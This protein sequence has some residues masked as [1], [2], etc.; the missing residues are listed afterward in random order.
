MELLSPELRAKLRDLTPGNFCQHRSWGFGRVQRFDPALGQIVIDF[1]RKANHPMQ[2]AYAAESL[3][4]IPAQHLLSQI[5]SDKDAF[6]QKMKKEPASILRLHAESFG[7]QAT[8]E[9]LEAELADK[10][11]PHAEYKKWLSSAKRGSKK[12]PQLVL[13]T[14]KN[15]PVRIREGN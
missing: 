2:I 5:A 1:D 14:R 13:P 4:P 10:V 12:D 3:T 6:I 15:E 8:L 7:D 11:L 9:R